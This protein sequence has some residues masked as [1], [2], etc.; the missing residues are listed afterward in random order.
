MS[1]VRRPADVQK[2]LSA[3]SKRVDGG[4]PV[5]EG[6][7]VGQGAPG[8]VGGGAGGIARRV[9]HGLPGGGIALRHP[10]QKEGGVRALHGADEGLRVLHQRRLAHGDGVGRVVPEHFLAQDVP[11]GPG[12]D[13]DRPV[14]GEGFHRI[15]LRVGEGDFLP[16][17]LQRDVRVLGLEGAGGDGAGRHCASRCQGQGA[18]DGESPPHMPVQSDRFLSSIGLAFDSTPGGKGS[19]FKT[20]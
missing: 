16:A 3:V 8:E 9:Q 10:V 17:H 11:Q 15:P 12:G 1:A 2:G 6:G 19:Q 13:V 18:E 14:H 5:P 7:G 4:V 20:A